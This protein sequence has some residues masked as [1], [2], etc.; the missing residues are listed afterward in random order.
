MLTYALVELITVLGPLTQPS[1]KNFVEK[2]A[3]NVNRRSAWQ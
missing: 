2:G 3:S 1:L